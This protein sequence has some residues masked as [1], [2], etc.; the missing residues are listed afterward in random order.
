MSDIEEFHELAHKF[1]KEKKYHEALPLY[2]KVWAATGNQYDGAGLLSCLRKTHQ[3]EKAIPLAMELTARFPD[4]DW[5]RNESIWTLIYG[6]LNNLNENTPF[7]E[8]LDVA[9][10]IMDL[11]PEDLALKMIVFRVL[12]VAKAS[13][14]W[15]V[16]SDWADKL[17]PE[18]LSTTP[19]TDEMGREGW[20]DQSLWYNYKGRALIELDKSEEAL[21]LLIDKT[22]DK[23]PKQKKFFI[24]LKALAFH[25][26]KQLDKAEEC[27][28]NLCNTARPD[29]W[30]LHE[31]ARVLRDK[32]DVKKALVLMCKAANNN[33][34]LELMINLFQ[35]MGLLFKE[36]GKLESARAHLIL[37]SLVRQEQGWSV[38]GEISTSLAEFTNNENGPSTIREALCICRKEWEYVSGT[39]TAPSDIKSRS[40]R[41]GLIGSVLLGMPDRPFCFIECGNESFFCRK[42]DLPTGTNDGETV[43]FNALPSFDVKKKKESWKAVDITKL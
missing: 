36:V 37:S 31:Y 16:V 4:F 17:N 18:K 15:D 38:P 30:L 13:D 20:C 23:Y 25:K 9:N 27:Y 43:N 40:P 41:R 11:R 7:E 28:E 22:V 19:M 10:T 12:K 26:L 35:E 2:E 1:W 42:S 21:Q 6:K 14:K 32:G 29:W 24:R 8:V 3:Y 39:I 33:R 34:K 5:G